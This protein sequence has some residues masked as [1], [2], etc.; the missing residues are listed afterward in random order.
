MCTYDKDTESEED[1]LYTCDVIT[2][3]FKD[4]INGCM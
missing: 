3:V 1:I 2:N 4:D